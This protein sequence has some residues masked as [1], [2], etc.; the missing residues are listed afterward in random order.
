MTDLNPGGSRHPLEGRPVSNLLEWYSRSGDH[1]LRYS[2][3]RKFCHQGVIV[4]VGCGHGFGALALDGAVERYVGLDVDRLAIRW[5]REN[6]ESRLP[7]AEFHEISSTDEILEWRGCDLVIAFE[8]VE[9]VSEPENLLRTIDQVASPSGSCIISTPNGENSKGNPQLYISNF[10]VREYRIDELREL[11]SFCHRPAQF[12]IE[13]RLDGL[14]LIGRRVLG[15]PL[16]R[17]LE[18]ERSVG[19]K[20]ALT[21]L[22]EVWNN[23]LNGPRFWRIA[24]IKPQVSRAPRSFSTILVLLSAIN[25]NPREAPFDKSKPG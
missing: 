23:R 2:F 15:R 22:N 25:G 9:H 1:F 20:R 13:Y 5:A 19:R 14:D 4:D 7:W 3:A 12:Y 8:V 10:H 11:L 6:V 18:K 24:P 21:V 17:N 16:G